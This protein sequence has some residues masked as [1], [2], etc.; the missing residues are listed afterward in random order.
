M[1]NVRVSS[2][3]SAYGQTRNRGAEVYLPHKAKLIFSTEAG[4]HEKTEHVSKSANVF[5]LCF[6]KQRH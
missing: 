5:S 1:G 6:N 3:N 4:M 2:R